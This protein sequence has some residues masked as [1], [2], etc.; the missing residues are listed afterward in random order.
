ML[1]REG[2]ELGFVAPLQSILDTYNGLVTWLFT[3]LQP[4]LVQ[5]GDLIS[6]LVGTPLH[7]ADDW[8][9]VLT[10]GIILSS[11]CLRAGRKPSNFVMVAAVLLVVVAGLFPVNFG[12]SD[13]VPITT[14]DVADVENPD[15]AQSAFLLLGMLLGL[16]LFLYDY[17]GRQDR[18]R[19]RYHEWLAKEGRTPRQ[20]TEMG[21]IIES[22]TSGLASLLTP[23]AIL[24]IP[25]TFTALLIA[26]SA[27]FFPE[28]VRVVTN[29]VPEAARYLL[30]LAILVLLMGL[31]FSVLE[32][33]ELISRQWEAS[34]GVMARG[35]FG[36]HRSNVL[37]W[38]EV[39]EAVGAKLAP[40]VMSI[41]AVGAGVLLFLAFDAGLRQA[42]W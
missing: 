13:S 42:G 27:A 29:R 19:E 18:R 12:G 20:R 25:L 3:P 4:V 40:L 24:V 32:S 35:P 11:A 38:I 36:G 15:P 23:I 26:G 8:R 7:L 21:S 30:V 16:E 39:V 28:A 14:R 10:A 9:H 34:R 2:F 33:R 22:L 31:W 1:V 17:K 41:I 6:S 37:G 5:V